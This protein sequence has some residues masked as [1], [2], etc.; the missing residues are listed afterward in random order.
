MFRY[1]RCTIASLRRGK[2]LH[3][4]TVLLRQVSMTRNNRCDHTCANTPL[5]YILELLPD[6]RAW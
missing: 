1:Y 5:I 6:K 2:A 4:L 3:R